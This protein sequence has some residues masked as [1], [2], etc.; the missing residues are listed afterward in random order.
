MVLIIIIT[1]M[2]ESKTEKT[3]QNAEEKYRM[4]FEN[5]SDAIFIHD[6]KG[7]FLEVNSVACNRLGYTK[8][9]LKEMTPM[10]ID[11]PEY[12]D[13]VQK[14][15]KELEEKGQVFFETAHVTKEGKQISIELSSKV[16][17]YEGEK[18]VLS[19]ARDITKRKEAERELK[20]Y[21]NRLEST[22]LAGDLA[23]WEMNCLTGEVIFNEQKTRMMGYFP[24]NFTHY[25]DFT[26]LLH[27]EDY[28]N[29]MQ[30]M[31]DHLN[32]A[33]PKYDT[34]YRIKTNSGDYKWF[35]DVGGITE[36]DQE[37]NP[38]KVTGVVVD[39]TESKEAEE[40]TEFLH[41]L[42]KHDL[43]NKAQIIQLSLEMLEGLTDEQREYVD[44][45]IKT[46]E[47]SVELIEKVRKLRSV[48]QGEKLEEVNL[49]S[50]VGE[51]VEENKEFASE[52][53]IEIELD[54]HSNFQVWGRDLLKE[55]FTNL[56]GNAIKHSGGNKIKVS[57][58]KSNEEVICI[59]E[60]DG[61]GIPDESKPNIF[62]KG[63]KTGSTAGTGLGTYMVKEIVKSY[64]GRVEVKD[65]ELGGAKFQI[66]LREF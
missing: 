2:S 58:A 48:E 56:I 32:G 62:D 64:G 18:A 16:I 19:I 6:L 17:D 52:K 27:P 33:T 59:I 36:V 38:V 34:E 43:R 15:I 35:H 66:Y 44:R 9:E 60:D 41:S 57:G 55:V 47:E 21:K 1:D 37:G 40:K 22:M 10:D 30:A 45:A 4:L 8:E 54:C 39:V 5:A 12:T 53:G 51:V 63:F 31:R 42:L 11:A 50:V 46:N 28:E 29:T 7:N 20:E 3:I 65:S 24:E 61:K 23:L 25:T 49:K 14:R 13:L 26:N